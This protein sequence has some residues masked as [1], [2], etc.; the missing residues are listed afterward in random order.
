MTDT[1]TVWQPRVLHHGCIDINTNVTLLIERSTFIENHAENA[2]VL[3]SKDN[4]TVTILDSKFEKNKGENCIEIHQHSSLHIENSKFKRNE[5]AGGSVPFIDLNSALTTEKSC[6]LNNT[7]SLNGAVVC[8]SQNSIL[9]IKGSR[10]D[11]N[12]GNLGGVIYIAKCTLH[13]AN[14]QFVFNKAVDGGA[15]YAV[16]STVMIHN[17]SCIHN[18]AKGPGG[19]VNMASSNMS[20]RYSNISFNEAFTSGAVMIFSNS[21]VSAVKTFSNPLV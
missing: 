1:Q 12:Y 11:H 9:N 7:N 6:F 16:F 15:I 14:S 4:V 5:V 10:M 13:V 19:C 8:G 21:D 2:P 17:S 20:L 3:L 18:V